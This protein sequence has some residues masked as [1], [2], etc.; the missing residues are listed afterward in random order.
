MNRK[1]PGQQVH[2][3]N[4]G[5]AVLY[6]G[7]KYYGNWDLVCE[8]SL[9]DCSTETFSIR[10]ADPT[11]PLQC[12]IDTYGFMLAKYSATTRFFYNAANAMFLEDH[13]ITTCFLNT[14]RCGGAAFTAF[15]KAQMIEVHYCT[16]TLV[17]FALM[18]I[19]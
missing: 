11:V 15:V 4:F 2:P 18:S 5:A 7:Q 13:R 10:T 19:A 6:I 3:R 8:Y 1:V 12:E 14:A 17:E 9:P 16:H